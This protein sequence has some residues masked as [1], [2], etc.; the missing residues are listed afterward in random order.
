MA[1]NADDDDEKLNDRRVW[2]AAEDNAIRELVAK[3][4]I[5]SWS[6]ISER[7]ALE[8]GIAGRS[9]KQCRE[10]WHNHLD[11][12]INKETWTEEEEHVMSEAHKELGNKW[13]EI[14]KRLPGRTDNHVKNHWYSFMRRNVRRLNR[15]VITLTQQKALEAVGK[16]I[17]QLDD[18]ES[19]M[20]ALTLHNSP[21]LMKS[22]NTLTN[23]DSSDNKTKGKN[24]MRKAANLSE[25]NRY[26][27]A[28]QE[29]AAEVI[30]EGYQVTDD[31]FN[32]L[33][34][35]VNTA[36]SP[37]RLVAL[38]LANSNPAFREKLKRKLEDSGGLNFNMEDLQK[39]FS[40][41]ARSLNKANYSNGASSKPPKMRQKRKLQ[42]HSN[43]DSE[44]EEEP[45]VRVSRGGRRTVKSY[46]YS[47]IESSSP[48]SSSSGLPASIMKRRA[49]KDLN[50]IVPDLDKKGVRKGA[51]NSYLNAA[52]TLTDM[53]P[54][55]GYKLRNALESPFG[56]E[57]HVMFG[58]IFNP[59]GSADTPTRL[60][61]D[62]I[63]SA[64]GRNSLNNDSLRFDFDEIVQQ[65]P[66]PRAG[67]LIGQLGIS[68]NR[69]SGGSS[70]MASSSGLGGSFFFSEGLSYPKQAMEAALG[71]DLNSSTNKQSTYAKKF[72]KGTSASLPRGSNASDL[73]KSMSGFSDLEGF[74]LP[75]PLSSLPSPHA[76]G[77]SFKE[78]PS[79]EEDGEA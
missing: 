52:G 22:D 67:D 57:K 24:G 2:T 64:S 65:F 5:K 54:P 70:S 18:Q 32:E 20:I 45:E 76:G 43:S 10:R 71:T 62:P 37:S 38:Q 11:P 17:D 77:S 9:G 35:G 59:P 31:N 26:F 12:N 40:K 33:A 78:Q 29:A 44:E 73:S 6:I 56:L 75:S 49:R 1:N 14:A 16:T 7:V 60:L 66:S 41:H 36:P 50:I 21:P 69:W 55:K 34:R 47:S 58:D 8:Y 72:K 68:P 39:D 48:S 42:L 23:G 27:R 79:F 28:A 30:D 63:L 13:S 19:E 53:G 46:K 25:L 51:K 74:I 61:H 4:G 15:E 3:F